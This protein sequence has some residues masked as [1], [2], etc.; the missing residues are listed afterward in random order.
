MGH[1]NNFLWRMIAMRNN[2]LLLVTLF[3]LLVSCNQSSPSQENSLT[4]TDGS[5]EQIY[6]IGQLKDL[7]T[8]QA[9]FGGI[10]YIGVPL[11]LLLEDAGYDPTSLSAVK[12]TAADGFSANYDPK[13]VTKSDTLVVYGRA[14]GPL[15]DDEG[16]FRMVLP[17]QEGK[18]NPRDLV[19][20]RVYP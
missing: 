7:G 1:M 13:L 16:T 20:L 6:N 15:A 8:E 5:N 10:T 2:L 11:Q 12:A 9:T 17:G 19:E 4:V 18:L 3:G 14:D